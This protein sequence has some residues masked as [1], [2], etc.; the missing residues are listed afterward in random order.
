MRLRY[1]VRV[2][3]VCFAL[4]MAVAAINAW[5]GHDDEDG[6]GACAVIGFL[7]ML[8]LMTLSAI[9]H[10]LRKRRERRV[11][12]FEVVQE[13]RGASGPLPSAPHETGPPV[14]KG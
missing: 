6:G 12:G 14:P 7:F 13:T 10:T 11:A 9:E 5:F 2:L 3:W 1:V 4:A 8:V